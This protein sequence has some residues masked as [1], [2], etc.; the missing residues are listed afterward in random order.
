LGTAS[1]TVHELLHTVFHFRVNAEQLW[2]RSVVPHFGR[3][4]ARGRYSPA[5]GRNSF[6]RLSM[7][8]VQ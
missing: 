2:Q 1:P 8:T 6:M 3:C 4:R 7:S 5:F